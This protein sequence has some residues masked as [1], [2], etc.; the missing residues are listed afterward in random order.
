MLVQFWIISILIITDDTGNAVPIDN[1][2]EGINFALKKS[3]LKY[4][5]FANFSD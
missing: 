1:G 2:I 3:H 5:L 4:F